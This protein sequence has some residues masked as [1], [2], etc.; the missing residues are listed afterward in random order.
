MRISIV[1]GGP[2]IRLSDLVEEAEQVRRDGLSGYWISPQN[3]ADPLTAIAVIG[4]VVPDIEFGVS[5]SPTFLRHP[6]SLAVQ[7]LTVQQATG[8]R[9]VL[10]IGPPQPHNRGSFSG[11]IFEQPVIHMRR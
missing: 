3:S 11:Y 9:L 1:G 2:G 4:R 8:G 6:M 10:N 7:A 5:I